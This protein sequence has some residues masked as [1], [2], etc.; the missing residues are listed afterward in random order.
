MLMHIFFIRYPAGRSPTDP[1]EVCGRRFCLH[2]GGY[3]LSYDGTIDYDA[4]K[5]VKLTW[6]PD[7]TT[8]QEAKETLDLTVEQLRKNPPK[9]NDK[10]SAWFESYV[11]PFLTPACTAVC[12]AGS[13]YGG[14]VGLAAGSVACP[15]ACEAAFGSTPPPKNGVHFAVIQL[16]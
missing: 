11:R 4:K 5:A 13:S 10:P 15:V 2:Y 12:I 14:P 16:E 3:T 1:G 6:A 8:L 9:D 7:G